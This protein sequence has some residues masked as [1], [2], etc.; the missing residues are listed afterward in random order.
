M[1][2]T[3]T[4]SKNTSNTHATHMQTA[5]VTPSDA[6]EELRKQ[7]RALILDCNRYPNHIESNDIDELAD[8]LVE[9]FDTLLAEKVRKARIDELGRIKKVYPTQQGN[10]LNT[11]V[12]ERLAHLKG[13]SK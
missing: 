1:T 7:A 5:H 13:A 6:R 10:T 3:P 9:L 8:D 2:T 4:P 12:Q 11:Y